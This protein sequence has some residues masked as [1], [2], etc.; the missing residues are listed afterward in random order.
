MTAGSRNPAAPWWSR[1]LTPLISALLALWSYLAR[2]Y[3]VTDGRALAGAVIAVLGS[4]LPLSVYHLAGRHIKRPV[5]LAACWLISL[6]PLYY[7]SFFVGLAVA[8]YT[9]CAPG[10]YECPI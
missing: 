8:A 2:A 10:Q 5:V 3:D 1:G 7:Y 9:Q 6:I 4:A